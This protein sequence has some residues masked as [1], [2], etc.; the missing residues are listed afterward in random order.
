MGKKRSKKSK[1]KKKSKSTKN[2]PSVKT[3]IKCVKQ[4]SIPVADTDFACLEHDAA[5]YQHCRNYMYSRYSGINS[6]PLIKNHRTL[7]RD[8]LM[9][10]DQNSKEKDENHV[11]VISW[12]R[13]ARQ[14]KLALDDAVGGIKSAQ[15]NTINRVRD[16]VR[17]HDDL[18]DDEKHF[19]Y[20]VLCN[21]T[22]LH[23]VLKRHA[24]VYPKEIWELK[25]DRRNLLNRIRRW[26]RTK[27]NNI[28]F[29]Y[30]QTSYMIDSGLYKYGDDRYGHYIDISVFQSK[31]ERIRIYL[32]DTKVHTGNLQIILHPE[33][34]TVEIHR[35]IKAKAKKQSSKEKKTVFINIEGC[36]KGMTEMLCL[37]S[38]HS[39]GQGLGTMI[40]RESDYIKAKWQKRNA[41]AALAKDA[42]EAGDL[43]EAA[44]IRETYLGS[45]RYEKHR[46][47]FEAE[48]KTFINREIRRMFLSE[49]LKELV[50][51]D[52]TWAS[53]YKRPKNVNRRLHAWM[54]GYI[55]ER[56]EYYANIFGAKITM[57]NPAHTSQIC[58]HCGG[59]G[60]RKGKVFVCPYCGAVMD[61]DDN[62][63]HNI[64]ARRDDK[65][66]TRY[67][68][69][70]KVREILDR[71]FAQEWAKTKTLLPAVI[72]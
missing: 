13:N 52:L 65:E 5:E 36:D 51:E 60:I 23:H 9:N 66:I 57:I 54:K 68:H 1:S 11:G 29:S 72:P 40:T 4:F 31:G 62:A 64:K 58:H 20:W 49:N 24:L 59:R 46:A 55:Q 12:E 45:S 71:R 19:C 30:N 16:V 33:N 21:E 41:Y 25:V 43:K 50:L 10:T 39:Y 28:P 69:K 22:R 6:L 27:K 26:Y 2:T 44:R 7:I 35:A 61:A 53:E 18:N 42:E 63:S 56:L 14:W 37:S 32:R 70:D 8:D 38:G 15:T 67:M 47:R 48:L 17:N 34:K 3:Y